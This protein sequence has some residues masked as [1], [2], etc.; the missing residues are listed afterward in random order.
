MTKKLLEVKDLNTHFFTVDGVV[1]AVDGISFTISKGET[2]GIVGESGSGKSVTARS[3]M[4]LV[5]HPPGK[6]ISGSIEF[7]GEDLLS[8]KE[9]EMRE[10]RGRK[11]GMIFQDPMTSLNPL[12]TIGNQMIEA[13]MIHQKVTKREARD[14][15]IEALKMVGIPSPETRMDN[16]PHN[17]SGGMRQRVMIAMAL[18]C[19]PELL[20]ADEPTTALDVTIQA[21]ILDLIKEMKSK[22]NM[23]VLIITH[24]LGVVAD[25]A[26]NII[27]M[28]A[29]KIMEY[30]TTLDLYDNPLHPYTKG[31][32]DSIPTLDMKGERLKSIE[33]NLPNVSL[34]FNG[35]RFAERCSKKSDRCLVQEPE[36]VK[37]NN[38]FVR[39][40]KYVG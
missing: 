37:V 21:Q 28:Y 10:I 27:V 31:L 22:L 1:P 30:G 11:I 4:R 18:S 2:L 3:I 12:F 7:N 14:K 20:I 13:I 6:I 8:K 23:S 34:D 33:G 26:D 29:G 9:S 24:D 16:Y 15:A 32:L 38:S 25:V 40:H 5:P 39:C 19:N 35:C 17:M 36:L